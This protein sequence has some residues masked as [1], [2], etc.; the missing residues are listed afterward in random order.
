LNL[1]YDEVMK[2]VAHQ[3]RQPLSEINSIVMLVSSALEDK[4]IYDEFIDKKLS[5]I[6]VLTN[7]MSKTID[8]FS[9]TD[10]KR[11]KE[12]FHMSSVVNELLSIVNSNLK[13]N[14]IE[15]V[16]NISDSFK[17]AGN[18][19]ILLQAILIIVNNAK[20]ALIDRNVFNPKIILSVLK[21]D[22]FY[23][24]EISDNGGGMTKKMMEKIFELD[25]STKHKS[26]SSGMGLTMS[27]EMI[28]KD[29]NGELCVRNFEDG[30]C[31]EIRLKA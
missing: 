12:F 22:E 8:D 2:K 24:I 16:I 6:E 13:S 27:K 28:E 7:Y 31:F 11:K 25:Y 30:T 17:Y 1:D 10:K 14:N 21:R 15:L 3:W 19:S 9:N 4:G 26:Q 20:D 18:A 5:E 29:F 23:I